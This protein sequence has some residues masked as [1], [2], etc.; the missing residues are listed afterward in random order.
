[1]KC[2][3]S[4][5]NAQGWR[6]TIVALQVGAVKI[7]AA[8]MEALVKERGKTGWNLVHHKNWG[9]P[10]PWMLIFFKSHPIY[11]GSMLF[12]HTTI[13]PSTFLFHHLFWIEN[14]NSLLSFQ[15]YVFSHQ[16]PNASNTKICDQTLKR[17]VCS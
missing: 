10:H 12:Y 15:Y 2:W 7:Y 1:M 9:P 3:N 6:L 16:I 11:E 4:P 13:L 5:F 8:T 14:W 17:L